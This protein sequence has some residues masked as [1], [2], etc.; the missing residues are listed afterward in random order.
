MDRLTRMDAITD[1]LD[2]LTQHNKPTNTQIARVA[3]LT[4]EFN[5]LDRSH[6]LN[7]IRAAAAGYIEA[8]TPPAQD[9]PSS[10]GGPLG[11][12]RSAALR[13]I[14]ARRDAPDHARHQVAGLLDRAGHRVGPR[15]PVDTNY[16]RPRL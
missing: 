14:D 2:R 6:Q 12:V 11:E 8:G 9:E 5:R 10:R 3:E 15:G 4:E 1:E 7:R 13:A 16:D